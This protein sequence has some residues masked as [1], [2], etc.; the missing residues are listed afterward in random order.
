VIES[1]ASDLLQRHKAAGISSV[2]H[3][4]KR[5]RASFGPAS[6]SSSSSS[7]SS[8]ASASSSSVVS[9]PLNYEQM[10]AASR[11]HSTSANPLPSYQ[12]AHADGAAA[13]AAARLRKKVA[14]DKTLSL[15]RRN[16]RGRMRAHCL[17]KASDLRKA[18][19]AV[20]PRAPGV[21]MK[22]PPSSSLCK[23]KEKAN[24]S[25][26]C[27]PSAATTPAPGAYDNIVGVT[28]AA[29]VATRARVGALIQPLPT[30]A[31]R[32]AITVAT[33]DSD[34][35]GGPGAYIVDTDTDVDVNAVNRRRRRVKGGYMQPATTHAEV[36]K[37]A[38]AKKAARDAARQRLRTLVAGMRNF[39]YGAATAATA[40]S[41]ST[42]S[43]NTTSSSSSL[44][45]SVSSTTSSLSSTVGSGIVAMRPD[46]LLNEPTKQQKRREMAAADAARRLETSLKSKGRGNAANGGDDVNGID[47]FGGGIGSGIGNGDTMRDAPG[48]VWRTSTAAKK[49]KKAAAPL[50]P[51]SRLSASPSS[52]LSLS[53]TSLLTKEEAAA[54]A[55]AAAGSRPSPGMVV[56]GENLLSAQQRYAA[57]DA[58]NALKRAAIRLKLEKRDAD[59]AD[60]A[61]AAVAQK[62]NAPP[63][64]PFNSSYAFNSANAKGKRGNAPLDGDNN[65][66]GDNNN[67]DGAGGGDGGGGGDGDKLNI[68]D[69]ALAKDRV[70]GG[71]FG[72]ANKKRGASFAPPVYS[73]GND[74]YVVR[75]FS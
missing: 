20:R 47:G 6:L 1:L 54:A 7:S 66:G 74:A 32:V 40:A 57:G 29:A 45:S 12:H 18:T 73:L 75:V 22:P 30:A 10:S 63:V 55:A 43:A 69:A 53:L 34:A 9:T 46:P 26:L 2:L 25:C 52:S 16:R 41:A 24:A 60:A 64:A 33:A 4:P 31:T 36:A 13:A 58:V 51:K 8:S 27:E 23:E 71:G 42:V 56:T 3:Q 5:L 72:G 11:R 39:S 48:L 68:V 19:D 44:A 14:Y 65:D 21:I 61:A 70:Y 17:S 67:D 15:S 28:A 49:T 38:R 37:A 35:A 50:P 62:E 59:A